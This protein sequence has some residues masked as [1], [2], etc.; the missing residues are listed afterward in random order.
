MPPLFSEGGVGPSLLDFLSRRALGQEHG[1]ST[2]FRAARKPKLARSDDS[3]PRRGRQPPDTAAAADK[4]PTRADNVSPRHGAGGGGARIAATQAATRPLTAFV[5]IILSGAGAGAAPTS[6]LDAATTTSAAAA[7]VVV[8]GGSS[9][10]PTTTIPFAFGALVVPIP[11]TATAA[12]MAAAAEAT[13]SAQAVGPTLPGPTASLTGGENYIGAIVGSVAAFLFIVMLVWCCLLRPRRRRG[14]R[15][16]DVE[17]TYRATGSH[18]SSVHR[19]GPGQ[20][21]TRGGGGPGGGGSG[22][23]GWADFFRPTKAPVLN[24]ALPRVPPMRYAGYTT[25]E[26]PQMP[27]VRRYP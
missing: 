20:A 5:T 10:V 4:L 3:R 24:Q 19:T 25:T 6:A 9:A 13:Q 2:P 7:S 27:G 15:A 14:R 26:V 17:V 21:G 18:T 23:G 11:S 12:A 1:E 8:A 16:R 22:G